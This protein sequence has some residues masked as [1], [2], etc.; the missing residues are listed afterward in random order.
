[1]KNVLSKLKALRDKSNGYWA[2]R[3]LSQLE[4]AFKVS[5]VHNNG[6]DEIIRDTVD[7]LA[8]N[9]CSEGT[10]TISAARE[11]EKKLSVMSKA[12]KSYKII[13]AA[14]AH[15]DMNWMWGYPETVAITL[16]TFRTMLNLMEEYSNFTFSQSQASVYRIVEEYD[17]AMLEEIKR[18]I[19]EGRWEVTAST[20]VET[21][22]NMPNGESLARHI[23]YTKKA[24]AGMLDIQPESLE[25]DFE[26]DTFGHNRNVPEIL[27]NGG[28]KFYYHC[29]GYKK[30]SIF[31]WKSPSGNSVLVYRE[32]AWYNAFIHSS[33]VLHVPEFCSQYGIN[34]ALKV[35]GVGNHGGGPTRRDIERILDM[36]FWPVFPDIRFG[37]LREYFEILDQ[38]SENFPIEDN[39]LNFTFTGC[40]TSQARIKEGNRVCE[41]KLNE[42]ESLCTISALFADGGYRAD[43]FQNAWENVL[44]NHF[45]DILPGSGTIDT[46]EYAM[47]LYQKTIAAA[48]TQMFNAMR[49]IT[50]MIDT[51]GLIPVSED[52]RETMSEGAGVGFGIAEHGTPQTERGRGKN[53]IYHLFNP[54]PHVR[55]ETV[56]LTVWDWPGDQD[57]IHFRNCNG[58]TLMHQVIEK[59]TG[60]PKNRYW[61]HEYIR[62]LV[63]AYIPAYGYT[64]ILLSE[65]EPED[66][67]VNLSKAPRVETAD[68]YVLENDFVRAQFDPKSAA[69]LSFL[70]KESN[71]EMLDANRPCGIFRIVE[72]DDVRGMTAWIIGR[73]MNVRALNICENVKISRLVIGKG[74]LRQWLEYSI[75]FGNS[76][77]KVKVSLDHGSKKLDFE[78]ECDWQERA[79]IGK[80]VPQLNFYLPLAYACN[81]YTYDIPFGTIIREDADMDVPGNSW[82]RGIPTEPRESAIMLMTKTKY[83]FRGT[84]H[85][86]AVT[87]LRSSYSPDPYPDVGNHHMK[88]SIC[89]TDSS[90]NDLP[91]REAFDYNHP[92]K[93]LSGMVHQG[94]LPAEKGFIILQ[95]GS[96][97]LSAVK[98]PEDS[99]NRSVLIRLY[100]TEGED[101]TVKIQ[102]SALLKQAYFTD[103]NEKPLNNGT[104]IHVENNSMVFTMKAHSVASIFAELD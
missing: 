1:M 6:Y 79:V 21:D 28:V 86:L 62:V 57:R 40:Y 39:E 33:M 14:H 78:V 27:S 68:C 101:T 17:P 66:V 65:K 2:D 53:R 89:I 74:L 8:K 75:L 77:L 13:C 42:A 104:N 36:S 31:Q 80:Y 58:N 46:R 95:E 43:V 61:S 16:D 20:W 32:P 82:M 37:T 67:P 87:L 5:K 91:V 12:A 64:T 15:I 52:I 45:H 83:G 93:F 35:Y 98:V 60:T 10:I 85:S 44:F 3:I 99:L 84:D 92:I 24:L 102:L 50:S 71:Q 41:A 11:A 30:H 18:R 22:K 51:E 34:T 47:G 100:E 69:I 48:N 94:D 38:S 88:F 56:E 26:P 90:R 55:E 23:L 19:R 103:I 4:Y 59:E 73:Y 49:N 72:E 96:V 29:R 70:D 54:S 7:L 76:T 25:I 81:R 97:V 63:K 9:H